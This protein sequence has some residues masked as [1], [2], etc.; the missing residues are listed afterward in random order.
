MHEFNNPLAIVAGR[1][2]VLLEERE[3]DAALCADLDQMLKEAR[4]M[5][6]IAGTLLKAL[7]RERS[8]EVFE[9]HP[10]PV[11]QAHSHA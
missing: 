1:L 10:E 2:E 8:G 6:N 7:R 5:S 11:R 3:E 4:Y 9:G